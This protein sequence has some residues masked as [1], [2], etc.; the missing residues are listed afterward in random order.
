MAPVNADEADL[1]AH[2]VAATGQAEDAMRLIRSNAGD[3][4]SVMK[5]NAQYLLLERTALSI[6]AQLLRV[7]AARHKREKDNGTCNQGAWAEHIAL[8]LG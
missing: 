5:L 3:V 8:G 2:C 7:Q 4:Q 6:H 1:A